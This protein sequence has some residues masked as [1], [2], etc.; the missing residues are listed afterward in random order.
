MNH[1]RDQLA[2]ALLCS[3][4]TEFSV[5]HHGYVAA[6][7]GHVVP[8]VWPTSKDAALRAIEEAESFASVVEEDR[9]F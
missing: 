9:D 1:A 2:T 3:L 7:R 6:F 4:R 5:P 8:G